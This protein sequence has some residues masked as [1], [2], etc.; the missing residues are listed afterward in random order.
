MRWCTP[1]TTASTVPREPRSASRASSGGVLAVWARWPDDG[2]VQRLREV[3]FESEAVI[4]PPPDDDFPE[5]TVFLARK[6]DND[7]EA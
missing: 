5:Y 7:Q 3:G 1:R 2:Y 4:V 6:R